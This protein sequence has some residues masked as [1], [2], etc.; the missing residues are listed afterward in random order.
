M[1][2]SL[3]VKPIKKST[4][5]VPTL[6]KSNST[7][8]RSMFV[9]FEEFEYIG[10]LVFHFVV[11]ENFTFSTVVENFTFSTV[12]SKASKLLVFIYFS[13]DISSFFTLIFTEFEAGP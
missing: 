12:W 1:T 6:H 5:Q 4:I 11:V 9:P 8:V 7:C 13:F 10:K 2:D 3:W